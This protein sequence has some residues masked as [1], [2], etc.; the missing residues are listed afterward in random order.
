M[1]Y[2]YMI[3]STAEC[4]II[5]VHM[6]KCGGKPFQAFV[7][8]LV[9]LFSATVNSRALFASHQYWH[10]SRP[11]GIVLQ[12]FIIISKFPQKLYHYAYYYSQCLLIILIILK[13]T[14]ILLQLF[15]TL[16]SKCIAFFNRSLQ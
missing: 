9:P 12:I 13:C 8:T 3:T 1:Q 7:L 5:P 15:F 14:A 16:Q 2:I 11:Q 6:L 4:K 10:A